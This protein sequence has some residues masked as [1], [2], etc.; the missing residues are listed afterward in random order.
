MRWALENE[1]LGV[2]TMALGVGCGRVAG[3]LEPGASSPRAILWVSPYRANYYMASG[4]SGATGSRVSAPRPALPFLP[5]RRDSF[6][7]ALLL[8]FTYP[9]ETPK[10]CVT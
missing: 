9:G 1:A 6:P 7:V 3:P 2:K 8:H 5:A 10:R 4:A